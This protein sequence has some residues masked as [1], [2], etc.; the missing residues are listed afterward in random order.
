MDQEKRNADG[1]DDC[2]FK[3][4]YDHENKRGEIQFKDKPNVIVAAISLAAMACVTVIA[5]MACSKG[6][7]DAS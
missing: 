2:A 7:S 6:G 5:G 1:K 4:Y 3:V